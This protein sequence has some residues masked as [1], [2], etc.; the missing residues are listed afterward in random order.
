MSIGGRGLSNLT[1]PGPRN[2]LQAI[3]SRGGA[4]GADPAAPRLRFRDGASGTLILGPSSV[5]HATSGGG[6]PEG[7]V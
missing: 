4:G 2:T 7:V 1:A 5:A 6:A 3:A